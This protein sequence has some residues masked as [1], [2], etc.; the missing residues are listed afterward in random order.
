MRAL[1]RTALVALFIF[2]LVGAASA[3]VIFD[4]GP[5]GGGTVAD[6]DFTRPGQWADDF[7]LSAALGTTI[8]DVHWWGI[9]N[10]EPLGAPLPTDDFTV[11]I[12][13]S[14]GG[15]P[16]APQTTPLYEVH[17]GSVS[18]TDTGTLLF[19]T[20]RVFEYDAFVSP[21]SLSA[22]TRYWLS[23]VNNTTITNYW[24]WPMA[25]SSSSTGNSAT[26]FE[27]DDPWTSV[28]PFY[29]SAFRLTG[30]THVVPE[31]ASLA[32]WLVGLACGAWYLR[33]Q[34]SAA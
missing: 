31:L 11:R 30:D 4:N 10:R 33:A 2:P 24:Q 21:I 22:G 12:F 9:Y 27:D 32:V 19:D 23:I 6:S 1:L 8:T 13:A 17:L 14:A 18:R 16:P 29:E 34:F 26:R 15:S 20:Y 28:I 5:P 3:A 7:L 25:N